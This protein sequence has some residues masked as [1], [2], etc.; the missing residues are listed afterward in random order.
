MELRRSSKTYPSR[1]IDFQL[2]GPPFIF[3]LV[4]GTIH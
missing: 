4:I 3:S 1:I 2:F